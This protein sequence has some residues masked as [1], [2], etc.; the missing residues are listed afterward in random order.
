M[1]EL[2][3]SKLDSQSAYAHDFPK[4]P[5]ATPVGQCSLKN[6]LRRQPGKVEAKTSYMHH[7]T[8]P[9]NAGLSKSELIVRPDNL[10]PAKDKF[11]QHSVTAHDFQ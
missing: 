1:L 10:H 7:F 9:P 6:N 11:G 2:S 8:E 4:Y 5:Y 3:T